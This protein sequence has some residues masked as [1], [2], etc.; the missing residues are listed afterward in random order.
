MDCIDQKWYLLAEFW[1]CTSYGA[2]RDIID[3]YGPFEKVESCLSANV[4][5]KFNN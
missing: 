5:G 1:E 2:G 4:D 3:D